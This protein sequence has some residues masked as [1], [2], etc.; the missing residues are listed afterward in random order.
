MSLPE[1]TE[2][3]ED[4]LASL[5]NQVE[6]YLD[7]QPLR[8]W[9]VKDGFSYDYGSITNAWH[10][11]D[12]VEFDEDW[13]YIGLD[14]S[15]EPDYIFE[16]MVEELQRLFSTVYYELLDKWDSKTC[17]AKARWGWRRDNNNKVHVICEV[18]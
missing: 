14:T 2:A 11:M 9:E 7:E 18:A 13:G 4:T 5:L 1:L 15:N 17:S 6:T 3:E 16:H 10:S 12:Y 8:A